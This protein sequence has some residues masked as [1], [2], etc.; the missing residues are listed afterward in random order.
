[1][2]T[3]VTAS[4]AAMTWG[5]QL[6]SRFALTLCAQVE[7]AGLPDKR[8][9]EEQFAAETKKLAGRIAQSGM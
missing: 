7:F 3:S 5:T 4:M 6:L 9:R 8:Y 2:L 1:M